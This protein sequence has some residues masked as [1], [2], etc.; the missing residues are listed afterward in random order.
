MAGEI[1]MK[2]G[3]LFCMCALFP[4]VAGADYLDDKIATLTQQ[5]LDKIA[6]L[7][8][9]Q[10]STKGLKIAGITTL[11]VSTIGIAANIG[12]AVALNKTED[13]IDAAQKKSSDLDSQIA[14]AKEK[15]AEEEK[16]VEEEVKSS[17]IEKC[18]EPKDCSADCN[19]QFLFAKTVACL[20][21]E[22]VATEC[23]DYV[24]AKTEQK[25]LDENGQ[26]FVYY[27]CEAPVKEKVEEKENKELMLT[28]SN[29]ATE[30]PKHVFGAQ[31]TWWNGNNCV[32]KTCK[33]GFYLSLNNG[34]TLDKCV[35][36]CPEYQ[37]VDLG[38]GGKGCDTVKTEAPV[39][40]DVCVARKEFKN[41]ELDGKSCV[42]KCV[43]WGQE[44]GC[45]F[46]AAK[47]LDSNK[48][49]K[50]ICNPN[51]Q[52]FKNETILFETPV[53]KE[54][55]K[56]AEEPTP[57]PLR[58]Q[59][60]KDKFLLFDPET[61]NGGFV[62]GGGNKEQTKP[63]PETVVEYGTQGTSFCYATV[64][65]RY[66]KESAHTLLSADMSMCLDKLKASIEKA[67]HKNVKLV[68]KK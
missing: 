10:K 5:K 53:K 65:G 37:V 23:A 12:E 22:C 15:K 54:V 66:F 9:C 49:K 52:D 25:C 55:K 39:V 59:E 38:N 63:A 41:T 17:E 60:N 13:K 44:Q 35:K 50:C 2:R 18:P 32:A 47:T 27:K 6:E 30:G 57:V 48:Y 8:K 43:A 62:P 36:T 31:D 14:A 45:S 64:A 20:G 61:V 67:G 21:G 16:V 34:K 4:M 29:C 46:D 68:K 1:K 40:N 42:A 11:G 28:A 3:I 19:G 7:E 56:K 33:E 26:E 58:P 51:A 24:T